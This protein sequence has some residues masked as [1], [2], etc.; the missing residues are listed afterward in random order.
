MRSNHK[1]KTPTKNTK[2]AII[3]ISGFFVDKNDH[4]IKPEFEKSDNSKNQIK[5]R[6]SI[7]DFRLF[8]LIGMVFFPRTRV[9]SSIEIILS[10]RT[11]NEL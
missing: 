11:I 8:L 5:F 10:I 6:L 3:E 4:S 9:E 1:S 7:N 2:A